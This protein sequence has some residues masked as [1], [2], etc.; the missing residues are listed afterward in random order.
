MRRFRCPYKRIVEK[1]RCENMKR[2]H[3][4]SWTW[5]FITVFETGGWSRNARLLRLPNKRKNITAP[6]DLCMEKTPTPP[7]ALC[8]MIPPPPLQ[9]GERCAKNKR[10]VF[11]LLLLQP[12][13]RLTKAR[14]QQKVDGVHLLCF[15]RATKNTHLLPPSAVCKPNSV[16]IRPDAAV[17]RACLWCN[18]VAGKYR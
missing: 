2:R 8:I 17:C 3:K 6:R 10:K 12:T 7:S 15:H 11:F 1:S 14:Q 13:A 9:T 18:A 4:R 5:D 16:L